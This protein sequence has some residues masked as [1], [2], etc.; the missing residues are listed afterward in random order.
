MRLIDA[1]WLQKRLAREPMKN[2]TYLRA[3]EIVVDAPTAYDVD[4]VVGRWRNANGLWKAR[5][6]RTVLAKNAKLAIV[7]CVLLI[8]RLVS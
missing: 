8:R 1:D 2:R 6:N 5:Y 7:L 4:K 3:N